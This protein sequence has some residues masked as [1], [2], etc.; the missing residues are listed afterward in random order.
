MK[1]AKRLHLDFG[2]NPKADVELEVSE[3][4][5]KEK[6]THIIFDDDDNPTV[7]ER[8][9]ANLKLSDLDSEVGWLLFYYLCKSKHL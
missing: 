8:A 6:P 3:R 5:F 7:V 2:R 9:P 4:Q 1:E